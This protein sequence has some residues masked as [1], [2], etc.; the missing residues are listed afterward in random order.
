MGSS[1]A[2]RVPAGTFM[3]AD[4]QR[5]V[6]PDS[7]IFN[8]WHQKTGLKNRDLVDLARRPAAPGGESQSTKRSFCLLCFEGAQRPAQTSAPVPSTIP[9]IPEPDFVPVRRGDEICRRDLRP[10]RSLRCAGRLEPR[11]SFY[12]GSPAPVRARDVPPV[13]SGMMTEAES[14]EYGGPRTVPVTKVPSATG[15]GPQHPAPDV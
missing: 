2:D 15:T 11:S 14:T 7:G 6:A 12:S 10:I 9:A 5:N 3:Q 8:S 4:P 1:S 13:P